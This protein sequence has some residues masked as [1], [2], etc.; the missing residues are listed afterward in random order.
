[1]NSKII[2]FIAVVLILSSCNTRTE[3]KEEPLK[4]KSFGTSD[5]DGMNLKSKVKIVNEIKYDYFAD[6]DSSHNKIIN[7]TQTVFTQTGAII[8]KSIFG[9]E[10]TL[11]YKEEYQYDENGILVQIR[12]TDVNEQ[13]MLIRKCKHNDEGL[14]ISQIQGNCDNKPQTNINLNYNENKKVSE[15]AYTSV[16]KKDL[17]LKLT[18]LYD[19]KDNLIESTFFEVT[20]AVETKTKYTNEEHGLESTRESF[21]ADGKVTE[22]LQFEYEFDKNSNWIKRKISQAGVLKFIVEREIVYF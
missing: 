19:D 20:N 7:R 8:E 16:D 13:C 9:A 17:L 10:N 3:R 5:W 22:S 21:S 12:T 6:P 1:M 18:Y 2:L 4:Q 15:I 11:I 14:L